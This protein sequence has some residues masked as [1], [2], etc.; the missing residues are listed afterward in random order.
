MATTHYNF[1]LPTVGGNAGDWGTLLNQ[2][3]SSLDAILN[4]DGSAINLDGVTIDGITLTGTTTVSGDLAVDTNTL[5]VDV[6]TNRVGIG[7]STPTSA[8]TVAGDI[9]LNDVF[10]Q[11]VAQSTNDNAVHSISMGSGVISVSADSTDV[12]DAS[13][14]RFLVDGSEKVRIDEGGSVLF[15]TTSRLG[16]GF[17]GANIQVVETGGQA[18]DLNRSGSTGSI[19]VFRQDDNAVGSVAVSA[20]AT[21]YNQTSDVRLKENITDAAE[22]NVDALQVRQF[23]WKANGEHQD[24][25]FIAQELESVAPYAVT[26]GDTEEDMWGVDY[27]KLVPMLVKEIQDLRVRVQQLESA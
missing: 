23:D 10:P 16:G 9:R 3:W 26:K 1:N 27:S 22:G 24:Y 13:S 7:T 14:I 4:G 11:I 17:S 20:T 8:L 21:S 25:G 5:F 2:N 15:G 12:F 19:I 18:V 6:S